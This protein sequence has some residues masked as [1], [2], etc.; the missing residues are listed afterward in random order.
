MGNSG[1]GEHP[2]VA[3]DDVMS[4]KAPPDAE[5]N[6]S[7]RFSKSR[8]TDSLRRGCFEGLAM[9]PLVWGLLPVRAFDEPD[10]R[11]NIEA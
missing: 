11:F 1:A 8:A 7:S 3:A 5:M 10:G 6:A 4:G 2:V 9:T